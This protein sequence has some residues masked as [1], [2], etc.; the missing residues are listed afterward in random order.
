MATS[1]ALDGASD[2]VLSL[3]DDGFLRRCLATLRFPPGAPERSTSEVVDE[4]EEGR[5]ALFC[6]PGASLRDILSRYTT[7]HMH[8]TSFSTQIHKYM[9]SPVYMQ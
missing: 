1:L 7:G 2:V 6:V 9:S 4:D 3:D 8:V 5:G